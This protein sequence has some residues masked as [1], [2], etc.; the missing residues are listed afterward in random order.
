MSG[1]DSRRP[2]TANPDAAARDAARHAVAA[3]GI[4]RRVPG[5]VRTQSDGM[6]G[7]SGG[8]FADVGVARGARSRGGVERAAREVRGRVTRDE[9]RRRRH[10]ADDDRVVDRG[11][12]TGWIRGG[13]TTSRDTKRRTR[14][15]P[16]CAPARARRW[17]R[18]F[19]GS[20][21]GPPSFRFRLFRR[22]ARRS[23]D[24]IAASTRARAP[25]ARS[26]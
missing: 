6:Y 22:I 7:G 23:A 25:N 11:G 5:R 13:E 4:A 19:G 1:F 12:A 8:V 21:A 17:G 18:V 3:R 15:D 20:G 9:T 16:G 2:A 26:V 14:A 24:R 10:R